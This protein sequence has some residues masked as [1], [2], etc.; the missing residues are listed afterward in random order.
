MGGILSRLEG[1]YSKLNDL[2]LHD[3]TGK[4]SSYT[5]KQ[6]I[7]QLIRLL[8]KDEET[9]VWASQ[10]E[11]NEEFSTFDEAL[12]WFRRKGLQEDHHNL[13]VAQQKS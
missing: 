8:S 7:C 2:A 1:A 3:K 11:D 4:Y 13:S 6:M 10:E 5:D 9:R 12:T